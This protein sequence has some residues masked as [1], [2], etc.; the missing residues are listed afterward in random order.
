MEDHEDEV[1]A[2]SGLG[3]APTFPM[4]VRVDNLQRAMQEPN[5]K[6]LSVFYFDALGKP[7][8]KKT[9]KARYFPTRFSLNVVVPAFLPL[10]KPIQSLSRLSG[11]RIRIRAA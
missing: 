11:E 2:K 9:G 5:P 7:R 6:V 3:F 10:A 1:R 4:S 8:R